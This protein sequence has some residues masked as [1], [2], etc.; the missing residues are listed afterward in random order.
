[1]NKEL[2][3]KSATPIKIGFV[4]LQGSKKLKHNLPPLPPLADWDNKN[5]YLCVEL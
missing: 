3:L 4:L 2:Q 1:M 5:F